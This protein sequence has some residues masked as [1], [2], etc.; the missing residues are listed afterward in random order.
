MAGRFAAEDGFANECYLGDRPEP[1]DSCYLL[2][3]SVAPFLTLLFERLWGI[4]VGGG[5]D[6]VRVLP[7][8][9]PG[10]TSAALRGL[11]V[12][13]GYLDLDWSPGKL[14]VHWRG[15]E[16]LTV[17]AGTGLRSLAPGEAAVLELPRTPELS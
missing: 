3:F 5:E 6:P 2:G 12:A 15:T 10:W 17:D 4:R 9:P 16:R 8:F 13:R 1:F 14:S 11:R 7:A